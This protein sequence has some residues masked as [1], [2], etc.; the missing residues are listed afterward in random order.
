MKSFTY[1]VILFISI[2]NLIYAYDPIKTRIVNQHR[3]DA[4]L[5]QIDISRDVQIPRQQKIQTIKNYSE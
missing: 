1:F 3:N 5:R 2:P 4:P